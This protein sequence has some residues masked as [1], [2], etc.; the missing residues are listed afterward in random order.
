MRLAALEATYVLTSGTADPDDPE[1]GDVMPD[2][3]DFD[4]TL[5]AYRRY[6]RPRK[7]PS[8]RAGI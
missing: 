6:R 8:F 1:D 5:V 2:L 4:Y 7:T 3:T